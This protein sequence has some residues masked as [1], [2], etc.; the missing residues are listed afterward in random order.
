MSPHWLTKLFS[1]AL[2]AHPF[3]PTG[4]GR[5]FAF[6]ALQNN[7]IL[8]GSFLKFMLD[9]FRDSEVVG[10]KIKHQEAVGLMKKF[11]FVAQISPK[12]KIEEDHFGIMREETELYI[13]PSL[14]PYDEENQ[15]RIPERSDGNARIVYYHLPDQF[16]PPMLFNQVAVTCINRNEEKREDLIW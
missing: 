16:L 6:D 13:V 15:K 9:C 14:L 7:G 4:N 10:H 5:D 12:T 2:I 3:Q 1:Y 11:K 8:L